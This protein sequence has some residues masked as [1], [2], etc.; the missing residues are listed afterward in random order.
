MK[1]VISLKNRTCT[2]NV[3]LS[4]MTKPEALTA[5]FQQLGFTDAKDKLKAKQLMNIEDSEIRIFQEILRKDSDSIDIKLFNYFSANQLY[6]RN[7]DFMD[8]L[9]ELLYADGFDL[10]VNG[11]FDELKCILLETRKPTLFEKQYKVYF[12]EKFKANSN[13]T[14]SYSSKHIESLHQIVTDLTV[15]VKGI[16][17]RLLSSIIICAIKRIFMQTL[18]GGIRLFVTK[19]AVESKTSD[20]IQNFESASYAG[21]AVCSQLRVYYS[22]H[23]RIE[24]KNAYVPLLK[25]LLATDSERERIPLEIGLE[26]EGY[27]YLFT[28]TLYGMCNG[29]LSFILKE[30]NLSLANGVNHRLPDFQSLIQHC[31][32]NEQYMKAFSG[33]FNAKELEEQK[34]RIQKV[35]KH[36]VRSLC[37]KFI[38]SMLKQQDWKKRGFTIRDQFKF[39]HVKQLEKLI[40]T[41][42]THRVSQNQQTSAA[43][44]Y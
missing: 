43:L 27:L 24:T 20:E 10:A 36:F 26:N 11:I 4:N 37:N 40:G 29:I 13:G 21:A 33:R 8:L 38:W 9:D 41:K 17:F 35:W 2:F 34:E 30:M 32:A 6:L 42:H 28:P 14:Y 5:C 44:Y 39:D 3:E 18:S 23:I 19:H 12:R 25:R 22:R 7:A 15:A 1:P 31:I 16:D